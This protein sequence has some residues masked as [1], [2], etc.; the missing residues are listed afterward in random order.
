M[1]YC[2][3]AESMLYHSSTYRL[4]ALLRSNTKMLL[5]SMEYPYE[6]QT[7]AS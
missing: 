4:Y 1:L 3:N 2:T 5:S 7:S 6:I